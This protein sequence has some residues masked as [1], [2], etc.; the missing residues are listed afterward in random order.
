VELF[1]FTQKTFNCIAIDFPGHGK[2]INNS[3]DTCES[4]K[5]IAEYVRNELI[6]LHIDNY[7]CLGH[8]MGAYVALELAQIDQGM[9]KL[10]FLHSN[11]WCD[12]EEKKHNRERVAK[13]VRKNLNVF[14]R[15]A[16]PNLFYL[17]E[18]YPEIIEKHIHEAMHI[19]ADVVAACSIAMKNR[20]DY[21]VWVQNNSARCYFIQG[22]YDN[23]MPLKVAKEKWAG[24]DEHFFVIKKCGHMGHIEETEL[25]INLLKKVRC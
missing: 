9:D 3:A 24:L 16:I 19:Q 7:D 13:V 1:V 12:D 4:I 6:R 15:E 20:Q 14:L 18:K 22:E 11:H 17:P 2:K 10:F 21:H 5:K 25:I 23:V 8:S